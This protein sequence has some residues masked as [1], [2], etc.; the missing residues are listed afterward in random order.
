MKLEQAYMFKVC[1][2]SFTVFLECKFSVVATVV[3][4]SSLEALLMSIA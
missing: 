1:T 2:K 4:F 3:S